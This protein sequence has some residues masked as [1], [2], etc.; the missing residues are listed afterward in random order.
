LKNKEIL[1]SFGLLLVCSGNAATQE[2]IGALQGR[3][4]GPEN[5]VVSD[6]PIQASNNKTGEKWRTRSDTDGSY[7]FMELTEGSYEVRVN[8]PCC[9]YRA[10]K[11]DAVA[12]SAGTGTTF[13]I[14]LAEGTSFNTIGDDFGLITADIL[15][16][17]DVPD[18]PAPRMPDGVPDLSGMWVYGRDPFPVEPQPTEWA[19][20]TRA[21]RQARGE[22]SP[23]F[24]C[25]PPQIPMPSHSPPP[26]GKFIQTSDQ[27]VI[28]YEGVLGYRQ[29]FLDG[30]KHPE[31][32][33]PGWLG[34]SVGH[35][36]GDELVVETIG[37]NDRGWTSGYP[38]TENLRVVERYQRTAYGVMELRY[39]IEDPEVFKTPIVR[40]LRID[41][42]PNEKLLEFVCE[43]NPWVESSNY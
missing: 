7:E 27:I 39:T 21:E 19:K 11:N 8:L 1:I 23:R 40:E 32:L 35:W 3:V 12:V 14:E 33:N 42:A 28:L 9:L 2:N 4:V 38:R 43:N 6:A 5:E 20:E 15:R 24:R 34:Y 31:D 10:Y 17:Q 36:E 16:D 26:M 29:I 13:D 37:F 30:R 18:L 41:L 22:V 25:L